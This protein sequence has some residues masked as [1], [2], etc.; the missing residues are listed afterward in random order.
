MSFYLMAIQHAADT[1]K[2]H[3]VYFRLAPMPG[4]GPDTVDR[5]KSVGHHTVGFELLEDAQED[6]HI[7]A[8]QPNLNCDIEGDFPV[9][10]VESAGAQVI[11]RATL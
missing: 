7:H 9:L 11:F 10:E 3:P 4:P 1:G 6:A 5:Y 8:R 2:Y